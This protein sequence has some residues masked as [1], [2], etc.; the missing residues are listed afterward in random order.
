[1]RKKIFAL[2]AVCS[3]AMVALTAC[4]R[5]A[6]EDNANTPAPTSTATPGNNGNGT[7][8]GTGTNGTGTNGTGTTGTGTGTGATGAKE[9]VGGAAGNAKDNMM[10]TTGTVTP[11]P[12]K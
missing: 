10:N 11:K 1:M 12:A 2:A 4:T 5:N 7:G 3:L 6:A 9:G 8:T